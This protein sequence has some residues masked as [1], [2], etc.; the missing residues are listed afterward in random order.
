MS[1]HNH[2]AWRELIAD[3]GHRLNVFEA[4]PAPQAEA[5]GSVIVLQEIF[6]VN[7]HIQNV[8]RRLADAGY[9]AAAPALFDRYE[10]KVSLAYDAAGI[11]KGKEFIAGIDLDTALRDVAAAVARYQE[12]GPVAVLGFCWGGSLAWLAAGR[13]PVAGAV[14]YYGGQIGVLLDSAPRRPVLTH[15]GE[16]DVS[17]PPS[18]PA[19]VSQRFGTILNHVYPAGH[20]FNCDEREAFNAACAAKAWRRTLGFLAGVV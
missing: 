4:A 6:G 14:A 20:G 15:F 8:T 9:T 19:E 10:K 17:I 11:A 3:D 7:P 12:L 16:N 5:R 18:V 2:E 1:T 13:L